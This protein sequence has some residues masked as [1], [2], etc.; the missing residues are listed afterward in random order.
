MAGIDKQILA[1]AALISKL[2]DKCI[3]IHKAGTKEDWA[4]IHSFGVDIYEMFEGRHKEL[5]KLHKL[6]AEIKEKMND[7]L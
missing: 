3:E 5:K 2:F 4:Q 7:N 1:N 6:F